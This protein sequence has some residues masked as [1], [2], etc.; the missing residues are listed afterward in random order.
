MFRATASTDSSQRR[1]ASAP[2][3]GE[4]R[5]LG[6]ARGVLTRNEEWATPSAQPLTDGE[7]LL[8]KV[9]SPGVTDLAVDLCLIWTAHPPHRH[10]WPEIYSQEQPEDINKPHKRMSLL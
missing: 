2:A 3:G 6:K 1:A 10:T 5:A 4:I 8:A 7:Q 9:P